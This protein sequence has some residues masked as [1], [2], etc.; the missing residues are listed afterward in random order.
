MRKMKQRVTG[1]GGRAIAFTV[2]VAQDVNK[3]YLVADREI[4][5]EKH[6]YHPFHFPHYSAVSGHSLNE[7][8]TMKMLQTFNLYFP[9]FE[10]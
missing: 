7:C 10:I 3:V 2:L 8:K 1:R 6:L 4:K 5:L 9:T